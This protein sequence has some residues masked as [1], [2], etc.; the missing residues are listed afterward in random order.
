MIDIQ[1]ELDEKLKAMK[2][3]WNLSKGLFTKMR[4]N[5]LK[6]IDH[7]NDEDEYPS[8]TKAHSEKVYLRLIFYF[9]F[10]IM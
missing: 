10:T 2:E 1:K 4:G 6:L 7:N 8:I 3:I 9:K 5:T